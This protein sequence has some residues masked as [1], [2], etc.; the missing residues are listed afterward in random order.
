MGPNQILLVKIAAA[1]EILSSVPP[2]TASVIYL[3]GA[4][5]KTLSA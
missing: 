1:T 2:L 4:P 5:N 3:L